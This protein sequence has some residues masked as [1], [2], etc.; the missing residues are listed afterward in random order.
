MLQDPVALRHLGT[1][2]LV[3]TGAATGLVYLFAGRDT[4]LSV[5]AR[6]VPALTATGQFVVISPEGATAP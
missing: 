4:P 1:S 5:D 2:S 6:D 3:V